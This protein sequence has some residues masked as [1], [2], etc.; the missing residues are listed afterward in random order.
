MESA[1][2]ILNVKDLRVRLDGQDI[3]KDV[4][5]ALNRGDTL[6]IVGPNGAGKSVLFRALLNLVPY[7]GTVAWAKNIKINYIPQRFTIDRDF[8]LTVNE[9]LQFKTKSQ[10][11]ILAALRSV[12]ITDEHHIHHHLLKQRL[13]WLS[14]GQIQ[15]VLI[16]WAIIDNP[17]VILFDEPTAGIDVGGE[18]TIYH[19]IKKLKD[20]KDLTILIISHDLNVVYKHAAS[21]LCLNKD[22]ICFGTPEDAL[23]PAA[24]KALYGEAKFFTHNHQHK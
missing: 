20:E 21:V 8:P 11:T 16:A 12:G 18:E 1:Q 3:I 19:L 23:D 10:R 5:F 22:M 4:S 24:L 14:G 13:G 17:D 2:P 7:S 9:F 15:R 6:A